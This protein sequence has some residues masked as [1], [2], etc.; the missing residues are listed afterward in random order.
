MDYNTKK[1]LERLA[2][3]AKLLA[4]M[5]QGKSIKQLAARFRVSRQAIEKALR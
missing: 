3:K 5:G 2:R 1:H 4:L